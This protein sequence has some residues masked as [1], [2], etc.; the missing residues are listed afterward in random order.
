MPCGKNYKENQGSDDPPNRPGVPYGGVGTW[1]VGGSERRVLLEYLSVLSCVCTV[2]LT[3]EMKKRKRHLE[4]FVKTRP[5]VLGPESSILLTD[6]PP[7]SA[8]AHPEP[9][10]LELEL[11]HPPGMARPL[12]SEQTLPP[13]PCGHSWS[14][15]VFGELR[16]TG[17]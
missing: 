8:R 5:M 17:C 2:C 12:L 6:P 13:A 3:V 11:H 16:G 7:G 9:S 1:W 15:A 10:C 14:Q 4:V